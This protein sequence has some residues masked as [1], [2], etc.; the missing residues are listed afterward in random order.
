MVRDFGLPKSKFGFQGSLKRCLGL[1][2]RFAVLFVQGRGPARPS[3]KRGVR[4]TPRPRLLVG[5]APRQPQARAE[6]K[7]LLYGGPGAV[8]VRLLAVTAEGRFFVG[9]MRLSSGFICGERFSLGR[10]ADRRGW[11]GGDGWAGAE[12]SERRC[13][14]GPRE[15][16][17]IPRVPPLVKSPHTPLKSPRPPLRS[18]VPHPSTRDQ[19][20]CCLGRPLTRIDPSTAP[21]VLLR[22]GLD[23]TG[24][25]RGRF[26]DGVL[27]GWDGRGGCGLGPACRRSLKGLPK[28][29]Q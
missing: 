14:P 7:S 11:A 13:S 19:E 10:P 28:R 24:K 15:T 5:D 2:T 4:Q 23:W 9:C 21:T 6:P 1:G 16:L 29:L 20:A 22:L 26:G 8:D 3:P 17:P 12:G 25:G 27:R 18:P